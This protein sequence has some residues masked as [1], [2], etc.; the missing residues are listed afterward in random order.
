M[1]E[2]E[3]ENQVATLL[4][5]RAA[6]E[7]IFDEVSTGAHDDLSKA[8]DIAR[9]MVKTFGMSPRLGQVSLEKDRRAR[10]AAVAD[11]TGAR[12]SSTASRPRAPSTTRS[13][14]SSTSNASASPRSCRADA[15]CWCGPLSCCWPR[16]RSPAR[17][18]A[19]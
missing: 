10:D 16:R 14:A 9:S 3:L 2:S 6:E 1:T 5:G 7:L 15:R 18:Y 19:T 13:A 11:R 17:S 8:T 12:A 4:G